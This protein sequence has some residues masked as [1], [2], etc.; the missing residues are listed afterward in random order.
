M[1][2]A[3][4][5]HNSIKV[6]PGST[7]N[8]PPNLQSTADYQAWVKTMSD[9]ILASLCFIISE[10]ED[11]LGETLSA[12]LLC[13]PERFPADVFRLMEDVIDGVMLGNL[14][15]CGAL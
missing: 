1:Y 15:F 2:N 7:S 13:T 14:Y 9:G 12:S 10:S 8:N 11:I 3:Y 4:T 5:A 6:D